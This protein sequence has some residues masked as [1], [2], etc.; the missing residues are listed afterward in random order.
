MAVTAGVAAVRFSWFAATRNNKC[1]NELRTMVCSR[2]RYGAI[3]RGKLPAR[4]GA[5]DHRDVPAEGTFEAVML[6]VFS[7]EVAA[8]T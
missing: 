5:M 8:S 7:G 4:L 6:K 3:A 2:R 1:D